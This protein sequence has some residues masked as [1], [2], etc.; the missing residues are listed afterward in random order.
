MT[1]W[2]TICNNNGSIYNLLKMTTNWLLFNYNQHH[3]ITINMLTFVMTFWVCHSHTKTFHFTG[4]HSMLHFPKYFDTEQIRSQPIVHYDN[5]LVFSTDNCQ[6]SHYQYV[7]KGLLIVFL[8]FNGLDCNIQLALYRSY[9]LTPCKLK[10]GMRKCVATV[11]ILIS[12]ELWIYWFMYNNVYSPF[13]RDNN[14]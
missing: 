8:E 6:S 4:L 3:K 2:L 12:Q 14:M 10:Y 11:K 5:K 9:K 1:K 7:D 13:Y